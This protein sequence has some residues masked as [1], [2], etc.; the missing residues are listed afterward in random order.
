MWP[1]IQILI[2][3]QWDCVDRVYT[4]HSRSIKL[5]YMVS[6]ANKN[7]DNQQIT[8]YVPCMCFSHTF[9][10]LFDCL[11]MSLTSLLGHSWRLKPKQSFISRKLNS[12][13]ET[14][15]QSTTDHWVLCITD[16][17]KHLDCTQMDINNF[18]F[19]SQCL[20]TGNH[21]LSYWCG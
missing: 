15:W 10:D 19:L 2:N 14:S 11:S 12:L 3:P 18:K 16:L 4:K 13:S 20:I 5:K 9:L 17:R 6:Q 8:L 1:C 21:R 7:I